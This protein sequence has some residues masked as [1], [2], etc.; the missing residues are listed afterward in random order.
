MIIQDRTRLTDLLDTSWRDCFE[1]S[2]SILV[3]NIVDIWKVMDVI[4]AK[5]C[6][7]DAD[8]DDNN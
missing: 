8:G 6:G 7:G 5:V 2:L 1:R 3:C 4:Y